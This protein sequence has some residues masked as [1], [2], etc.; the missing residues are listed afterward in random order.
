VSD[1]D[2]LLDFWF[3]APDTDGNAEWRKVWFEKDATFDATIRARFLPLYEAASA[4]ALQAWRET[5][6]GCLALCLL[7]DQLPRNLFRGDPRAFATDAAARAVARHALDRGFDQAV[8]PVH[9]CFFYLPYEHSEDPADQDT[10]VALFTA[11]P[12]ADW[13]ARC[14]DA[15]E[16]H[17][18]VIRR[19][20][21][22]PHRNA[23]LGRES[24]PAE[25][26]YLARPDAGF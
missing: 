14:I 13:K 26:E 10:C 1:I 21:R 15:A 17:R 7:L 23:A 5:P 24:T 8:S 6:Q 3:G 2:A 4:G 12:E 20:A 18:D 9:R 19:F 16:R 11:L 22:F 25:Q